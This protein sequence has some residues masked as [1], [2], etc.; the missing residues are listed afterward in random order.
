MKVSEVAERS[1]VSPQAVR[2]YC[3]THFDESKKG[4]SGWIITDDEAQIIITYYTKGRTTGDDGG[5]ESGESTRKE[6]SESGSDRQISELISE[7]RNQLAVKDAQ[8]EA[9]SESLKA[10][11]ESLHAAQAL[12]GADVLPKAMEAGAEPVDSTE[13]NNETSSGQEPQRPTRW[14]YFKA[15]FT[16]EVR[17]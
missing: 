12:H 1:G 4:R 11:H 9:L 14:Q 10:A 5:R 17:L 13:I 15:V 16:G 8:I 2:E 3:R 7:L 6:S